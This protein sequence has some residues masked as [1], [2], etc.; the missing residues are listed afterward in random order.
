M[1]DSAANEITFRWG[2]GSTTFTLSENVDYTN[3]YI[4]C[5]TVG[6][7]GME[8][9]RD[10]ILMDVDSG[11]TPTLITVYRGSTQAGVKICEGF[12]IGTKA[13]TPGGPNYYSAMMA[14]NC[15]Y[16]FDRQLEPEEIHTIF[17]NF[18]GL[19]TPPPIWQAAHV[20][21]LNNR[22]EISTPIESIMEV[23]SP[24]QVT[25]DSVEPSPIESIMEV[26]SPSQVTIDSVEPSPIESI[27]EVQS[28]N[29][30]AID[31]V[32]PTSLEGY[33]TIEQPSVTEISSIEPSPVEVIAEVQSLSQAVVDAVQALPIEALI[34]I[35]NTSNQA[36]DFVVTQAV[37]AL[38]EVQD[39][40][41]EVTEGVTVVPVPVN[42]MMAVQPPSL[43][44]IVAVITRAAEIVFGIA[45]IDITTEDDL[46]Y[47]HKQAIH[48]AIVEALNQGI[49]LPVTYNPDTKLMIVPEDEDDAVSPASIATNELTCLFGLPERN[50]RERIMERG[51]WR[52]QAIVKFDREVVAEVFEEA[53]LASPIL[54]EPDSTKSLRR[55]VLNL[56]NAEYTHPPRQGSSSGTQVIYT[57]E[58]RLGPV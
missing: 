43:Q 40:D 16:T 30:T 55:I 10:S 39:P 49:F 56:E 37:E 6:P 38:F 21:P 14:F 1:P 42:I 36:L 58:A 8:C 53:L 12:G 2:D 17:D 22:I 32:T 23:Q 57:F 41:L 48:N 50:R 34:D 11:T 9:W 46:F 29:Q 3:D 45:R 13:Y 5:F 15:L 27:M 35:K 20:G 24:S 52:W 4:W 44:D 25:I 18:Y 31:S 47:T 19:I 51:S 54:I 7:R 28:P 26:Q 33:M